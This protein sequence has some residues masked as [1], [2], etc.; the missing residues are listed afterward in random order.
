VEFEYEPRPDPFSDHRAGA[1]IRGTLR[2]RTTRVTTHAADT[3]TP[4]GLRLPD[5]D[6]VRSW[7]RDGLV[8]DIVLVMTLA[9]TTPA[10]P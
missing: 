5:D 6:L 3:I 4:G 7:F 1:E 8:E 9:G 2:C 10:W